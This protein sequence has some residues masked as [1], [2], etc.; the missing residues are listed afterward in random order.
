VRLWIDARLLIQDWTDNN[1]S[2]S[3]GLVYL[4]AGWHRLRVDYYE[5]SGTASTR[6]LWNYPFGQGLRVVP[7]ECLGH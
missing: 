6:V 1:V 7:A 5:A 4:E 3:D 2:R